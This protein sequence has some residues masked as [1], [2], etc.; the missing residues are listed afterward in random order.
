MHAMRAWM[1]M[2]SV[3]KTSGVFY[4]ADRDTGLGVF[5]EAFGEQA[6]AQF[7]NEAVFPGHCLTV[8]DF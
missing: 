7:G 1:D 5:Q 6:F 2:P 4:R 8:E 3:A